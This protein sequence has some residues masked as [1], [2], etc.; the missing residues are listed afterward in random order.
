MGQGF[1]SLSKMV[2]TMLFV[3]VQNVDLF[4]MT[5][6]MAAYFLSCR[7]YSFVPKPCREY[8]LK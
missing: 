8:Y 4:V 1:G 7:A 2:K 3:N 5:P 6:D